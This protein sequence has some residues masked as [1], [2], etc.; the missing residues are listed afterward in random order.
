[1]DIFAHLVI[2][3]IIAI[4]LGL[5]IFYFVLGGVI[6]DIDHFLGYIYKRIIKKKQIYPTSIIK[7]VFYFPRTF[8]HS[9]F[10]VILFSLILYAILFFTEQDNL[11]TILFSFSI[12]MLLHLFLDSFDVL[13]IRWVHPY[14]H[15]SGKLPVGYLPGDYEQ[16][17]SGINKRKI[18]IKR[19]HFNSFIISLVITIL[20]LIIIYVFKR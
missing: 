17:S 20:A 18:G 16:E 19:F 7:S 10:G 15:I 4:F 5:N 2:S 3:Y 13:G 1:M 9:L 14:L 12:G 6:L 8:L 11:T